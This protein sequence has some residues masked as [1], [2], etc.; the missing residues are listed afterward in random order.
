MIRWLL[1]TLV[2]ANVAF[3]MW[4]S[5]YKDASRSQQPVQRTTINPQKMRLISE[6]AVKAKLRIRR[7][8]SA[9]KTL[10]PVRR[11]CHSVGAFKSNRTAMRAGT[12][13]KK[14]GLEYSLRTTEVKESRY[15]IYLPP[16]KSHKR[17]Q[18]MRKKLSRLGFRDNALMPDRGLRNAISVGIFTVKANA[19]QRRKELRKKGIRVLQRRL[20]SKSRRFWL[21]V[22][23]D[24]T[25]HALLKTIRWRQKEVVIKE[26]T[27]ARAPT[28]ARSR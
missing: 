12:R 1:A 28:T 23:T 25:K 10:Q 2:L 18:A 15:Q 16:L 13:L 9:A 11:I 8:Q 7:P 19:V 17:A 24:E 21:D 22:P 6:P 20:V 26:S 3:F 5:W 27:C 14:A 4:G